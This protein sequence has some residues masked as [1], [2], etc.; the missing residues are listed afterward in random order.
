MYVNLAAVMQTIYVIVIFY[1]NIVLVP[2]PL[3]YD[4]YVL[5]RQE[6]LVYICML[7]WFEF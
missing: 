1:K 5:H 6:V 2:L 3:Q 4:L 7:I